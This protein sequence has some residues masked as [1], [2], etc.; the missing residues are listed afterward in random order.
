MN[1]GRRSQRKYM[2]LVIIES[3]KVELPK[4]GKKP[5]RVRYLEM[6]VIDNLRSE[7]INIVVNQFIAEDAELQT[8]DSTSNVDLSNL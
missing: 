2:V 7:T 6:K 4:P 3:E 5:S 8:D 1:R